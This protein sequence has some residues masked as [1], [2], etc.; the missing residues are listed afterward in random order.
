MDHSQFPKQLP[1]TGKIQSAH[2][3]SS[4]FQLQIARTIQSRGQLSLIDV[5]KSSVCDKALRMSN[6][7][8][9]EESIKMISHGS[10][11]SLPIEQPLNSETDICESNFLANDY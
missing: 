8:I 6:R 1:V 3:I 9:L 4:P 7:A 11:E 10:S 5:V 2:R